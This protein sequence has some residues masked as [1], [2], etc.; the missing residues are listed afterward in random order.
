MSAYSHTEKYVPKNPVMSPMAARL[1]NVAPHYRRMAALRILAGISQSEAAALGGIAR[2]T[3][4]AAENGNRRWR[5]VDRKLLVAYTLETRGEGA[6]DL[7]N[8]VSC[9][10]GGVE[11]RRVE[12]FE[13]GSEEVSDALAA[14]T[15]V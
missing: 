13:T 1:W 10:A 9:T 6:S 12:L 3:L 8:P 15:G 11:N 7:G 4:S 5:G 14:A 2:T